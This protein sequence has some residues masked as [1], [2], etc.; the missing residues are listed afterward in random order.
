[1]QQ[2]YVFRVAENMTQEM[3]LDFNLFHFV[4]VSN[5]SL[6]EATTIRAESSE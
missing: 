4:I 1:M 2:I 3:Y 5:I 6:A